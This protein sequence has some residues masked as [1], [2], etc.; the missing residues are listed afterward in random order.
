M[1]ARMFRIISIINF[2]PRGCK[3]THIY[4]SPPQNKTSQLE[5]LLFEEL[6]GA[7]NQGSL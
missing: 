4:S 6:S 5:K 1:L 3:K 7:A 2:L